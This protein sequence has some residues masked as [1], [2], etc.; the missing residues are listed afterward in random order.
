MIKLSTI[1]REMAIANALSGDEAKLG[2]E[3][4]K[5]IEAAKQMGESNPVLWRGMVGEKGSNLHK[6]NYITGDREQFR[7]STLGAT[8]IIQELGIK[9]PVFAFFE[10]NLVEFFGYPCILVLEKPYKMYQSPEVEDLKSY[11][12][13]SIYKVEKRNG[14]IMRTQIGRRTNDEVVEK[15]K[16][17]AATYKQLNGKPLIE[18]REVIIDVKNYWAILNIKAKTYA[19]VVEYLE[20][21]KEYE[22]S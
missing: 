16:Q 13:H 14:G 4:D 18:N 11:I 10:E 7:G 3:I 22:Q 20:K 21:Y 9:H 5:V 17:G 8:T 12:E 6:I 1:L 2:S 19:D 15:A